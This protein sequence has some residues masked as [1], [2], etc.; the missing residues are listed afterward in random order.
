MIHVPKDDPAKARL[1]MDA[2]NDRTRIDIIK[3]LFQAPQGLTAAYIAQMLGKTIPTIL[4]HLNI[5]TQAGIINVTYSVYRGRTIKIYKLVETEITLEIDLQKYIWVP[6]RSYLDNWV[7]EYIRIKRERDILPSKLNVK[8]I[9]KVLGIDE[10]SAEYIK[11]YIENNTDWL[12]AL[13]NEALQLISIRGTISISDLS[14]ELGI[15]RTWAVRLAD[16]LQ[17]QGYVI[18]TDNKLIKKF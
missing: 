8:D 17:L 13:V 9:A 15:A 12:N 5:L 10:R 2:I 16:L 1:V 4:S 3:M 7:T 14:K 18:R 6:F 11:Q